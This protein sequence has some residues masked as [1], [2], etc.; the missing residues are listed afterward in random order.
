MARFPLL[1]STLKIRLLMNIDCCA[2]WVK[3]RADLIETFSV[4][5]A[6]L[7]SEDRG[8]PDFKDWQVRGHSC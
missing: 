1:L 6:I 3:K 2:M 7:V 5:E 4:R 8:Q